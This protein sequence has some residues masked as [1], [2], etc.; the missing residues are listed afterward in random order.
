MPCYI[1]TIVS[2]TLRLRHCLPLQFL[3][4]FGRAF[5]FAMSDEIECERVMSIHALALMLSSNPLPVHLFHLAT[6]LCFVLRSVEGVMVICS[7]CTH[8]PP[9][10]HATVVTNIGELR[11]FAASPVHRYFPLTWCFSPSVNLRRKFRQDR[12]GLRIPASH[13]LF[14]R[15]SR[16]VRQGALQTKHKNNN[17]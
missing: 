8:L 9:A 2:S 14:G 16:F 5:M 13:F 10:F 17:K 11:C 15:F 1:A 7:P 6:C 12:S 4:H 3:F